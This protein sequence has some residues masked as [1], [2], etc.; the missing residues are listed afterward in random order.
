M[1]STGFQG[2][3][4]VCNCATGIVVEVGFNVAVDDTSKHTNKLVDLTRRGTLM[5]HV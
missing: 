1:R 4:G 5:T 2:T 3:E